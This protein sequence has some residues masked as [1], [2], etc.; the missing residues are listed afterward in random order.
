MASEIHEAIYEFKSS[1]NISRFGGSIKST[2]INCSYDRILLGCTELSMLSGT[3]FLPK[4]VV[5]DPIE[6]MAKR[7]AACCR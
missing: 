7:I 4:G 5:I 2:L 6:L 3:E 1:N